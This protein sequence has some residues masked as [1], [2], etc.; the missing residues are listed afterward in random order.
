MR[1]S[2]IMEIGRLSNV[3]QVRTLGPGDVERIFALSCGNRTFYQYHPP[4]VTR[5]SILEDMEALPPGKEFRDKYYV[6]FFSGSQLLA[7]MDLVLDYPKQGIGF[8]GLFMLE[9]SCQGR[10]LGSRLLEEC[11]SCLRELGY[12]TVRLGA[13]KEN[14]QSNRFW[15]KNGFCQVAE[16]ENYRI[17]ERN[18][19]G[20]DHKLYH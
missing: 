7:V 13:D 15:Q 16:W 4:F 1:E 6:G 17:Y 19:Y 14:P 10:G 8:I 20:E 12:Q 3:Y 11:L 9:E 18:L 5:E 2:G